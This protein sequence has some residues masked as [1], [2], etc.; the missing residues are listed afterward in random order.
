MNTLAGPILRIVYVGLSLAAALAIA[1][2]ARAQAEPVIDSAPIPGYRFGEPLTFTLEAHSGAPI[3]RVSLYVRASEDE[4]TFMGL[5]QFVSSEQVTATYSFDP[6]QRTLS[7]YT[8]VEYWWEVTDSSGTSTRSEPASF[9][10]VDNR[11]DWQSLETT[12][13]RLAVHWYAG[14]A[15]FGQAALDAATNGY[16][17]GR[18]LLASA[19]LERADV[20]VYKSEA[21]ARA[22]LDSASPFWVSGYANP[23]GNSAII[24]ADPATPDALSQVARDIPHELMHLLAAQSNGSRL[25]GVPAWFNEGLAQLNEPAPDPDDAAL[26]AN[27][28][29]AGGLRALAEYCAPF[30]GDPDDARLAY[31]HSAAVV[32]HIR[33]QFGV[34][35]LSE[36]LAAYAGGL[37]CEAGVQEALGLTLAG[38]DQAWQAGPAVAPGLLLNDTAGGWLVL[39]LLV[40]VVAPLVLLLGLG[41]ARPTQPADGR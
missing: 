1:A 41:G 28:R 22:A 33:N 34:T 4:R 25:Q 5:A 18:G 7:A 38:L 24:V 8:P 15:A 39:A 3:T 30:P 29:A 6:H 19:Q 13:G 21:D 35:K 37:S 27:A 11:F 2:P 36:L 31:A 23:S 12:D 10:Y 16:A 26:L 40:G 14:D 9:V 20:Y 17:G 32:R